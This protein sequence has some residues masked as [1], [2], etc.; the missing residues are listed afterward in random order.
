MVSNL[1]E[2]LKGFFST[3]TFEIMHVAGDRLSAEAAQ[4]GT[5]FNKRGYPHAFLT[6]RLEGESTVELDKQGPEGR[7]I[8]NAESWQELLLDSGVLPEDE[9]RY[10]LVKFSYISPTDGVERGATIFLMW[11]PGASKVKQKMLC[12]MYSRPVHIQLGGY[13]T[14]IQAGTLESLE[15]ET[16]LAQVLSKKTVK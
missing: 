6:F 10:G 3:T 5:R 16:V 2:T 11:C 4:E 13:G 14:T 12:T 1:F 8:T 7:S 9:P 15:W